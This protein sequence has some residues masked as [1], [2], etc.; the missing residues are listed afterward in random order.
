MAR[1]RRPG[2]G[3]RNARARAAQAVAGVLGGR[4]LDEALPRALSG[5]PAQDHGLIRAMTYA[6]VRELG[7]LRWLTK[8]LTPRMP[9]DPVIALLAVGL[10]QLRSLRVPPHAAVSETV[11]AAG[12]IGQRKAG[13]LVNA[14]LRR[15]QREAQT[16]DGQ[17]PAHLDHPDWLVQQLRADWPDRWRELLAA[18]D[19][20]APMTLRVNARK[21][22]RETYAQALA[23]AGLDCAAG[24]P[25]EALTLNQPCPVET[26]PG[27]DAGQVS[28]QD[29]SAQLAAALLAPH[30]GERVLDACAAP[31]GKTA[32]LLE[33]ADID[34]TAVDIDG[35]RQ[36][37]VQQTLDRLGLQATVRTGDA[38]RPADWWDGR[39]FDAILVDAPCSGTGVIRR[40]PD[41][42]W[43]RRASDIP[44][45]ARTQSALLDALWPLLAPGG[46]LLYATCS[47][48]TAENADVIDAFL[49]RQGAARAEAIDARWGEA[50]GAGRRIAPGGAWDGFYYAL[51]RK[52]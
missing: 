13:G 4:S 44:T 8:Q 33:R 29:G 19:S 15:Y 37:R 5:A 21:T 46:R 38:A 27:F 6:A 17:L 34:L 51:L 14:V 43:L 24:T 28:V 50:A 1:R 36:T 35:D 2:S 31:G 45:L 10:V 32:H 48:L 9:Q 20:A 41:I 26:L 42:K 11:D 7:S 52:P 40:H 30:S 18:G 47:I 25:P 39:P 22:T 16:L 49:A 12:Q 3:P 23:E